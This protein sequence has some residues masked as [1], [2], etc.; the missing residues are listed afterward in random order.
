MENPDR[1]VTASIDRTCS[2]W[3]L[4]KQYNECQLF[5]HEKEVF[6]VTFGTNTYL[7]ATVGADGF[8]KLFD[9]RDPKRATLIF[10]NPDELPLVRIAWNRSNTNYFAAFAMNNNRILILDR[11]SPKVP[12]FTIHK[13][14]NY[15]NAVTWA[16]GIPYS[17][18]FT[19]EI[20]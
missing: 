6:D 2:V 7:F 12:V 20:V 16:P 17:P 1:I 9:Q 14:D 3:N 8:A 11:R 19:L 18:L 10:K 13:H 5:A 4:Q 15:I